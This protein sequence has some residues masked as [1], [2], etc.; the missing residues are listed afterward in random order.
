MIERQRHS[1]LFGRRPGGA[2]PLDGSDVLTD[3]TVPGIS[4]TGEIAPGEP[5]ILGFPAEDGPA[6]GDGSDPPDW[7]EPPPAADE[8]GPV[9][10][11]R[12]VTLPR[13][14]PVAALALLLAGGAAVASLWVAWWQDRS[15][16]GWS[17][18]RRGL[19]LGGSAVGKLGR[20]DL[21]PPL[22]IVFGGVL[23]FLIGVVLFLPERTHRIAGLLALLVTC[24][25][26]AGVL[27][28]VARADW[29]SARFGPGMW[30][31]IAVTALGCLGALRAMLRTPR[32]TLRPRR[33]RPPV[34]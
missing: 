22:A 4:L 18:V 30:L 33:G 15:D 3:R 7:T 26:I 8:T 23:L 17:L 29:N 14:D 32:V 5:M 2:P 34:E 25:P 12:L 27:F 1:S 16:T 20:S 24:G 9:A 11:V 13:A 21:W 31:A 6:P 28:L 10:E 19:A